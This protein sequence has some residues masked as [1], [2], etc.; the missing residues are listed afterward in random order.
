TGGGVSPGLSARTSTLPVPRMWMPSLIAAAYDR[1]MMRPAWNGPRSFTRTV[2]LRPLS[3]LVTRA[4]VGSGRVLCAAL[5]WYMSYGS[6]LEVARPWN[7][8]PYHD[9]VPRST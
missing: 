9:A 4:Y 2:T 7:L 3:R 1:S 8:L 6:R 5:N